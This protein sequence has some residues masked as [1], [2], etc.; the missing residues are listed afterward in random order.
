MF[1]L[2]D[3]KIFTILLSKILF[4]W[5]YALYLGDVLFFHGNTLH[6][7]NANN[8]DQRRT[9]LTVSYNRTWNNPLEGD[10][11]S[12]YIPLEKVNSVNSP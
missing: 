7:S 4:I 10:P 11:H 9:I 8:S 2:M 12:K 6:K 3:K 5:T 1:K